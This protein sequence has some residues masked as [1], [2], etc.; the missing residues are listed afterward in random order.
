MLAGR[1]AGEFSG[2]TV[3]DNAL[4]GLIVT[5]DAA[6]TV[7]D[8]T[9]T[10]KARGGVLYQQNAGGSGYGTPCYGNGGSDLSAALTPDQP[11]PDFNLDGCEPIDVQGRRLRPPGDR[12][13]TPAYAC[14]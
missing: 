11:G 4:H 14:A 3:S 6:P 7:T 5:G 9:V 2:N 13:L 8:N 1:S 10:G 12:L